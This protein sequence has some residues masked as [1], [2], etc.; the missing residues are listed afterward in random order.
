M[1][2]D[3]EL[4]LMKALCAVAHLVEYIDTTEQFDFNSAMSNLND[5]MLAQWVCEN[6]VLLPVR[7]DG[8]TLPHRLSLL[9]TPTYSTSV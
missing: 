2:N 5:P 1:M 7:R 3:Q 4:M 8:K 6:Q 9:V